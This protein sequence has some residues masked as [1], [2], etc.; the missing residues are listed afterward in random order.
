MIPVLFIVLC[1]AV[2][3]MVR[4]AARMRRIATAS[5]NAGFDKIPSNVVKFHEAWRVKGKGGGSA[6]WQ[7]EKPTV[8]PESPNAVKLAEQWRQK[9]IED[10]GKE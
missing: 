7:P 1:F 4:H 6:F 3:L 5:K 2:S 10:G 9:W 8:A